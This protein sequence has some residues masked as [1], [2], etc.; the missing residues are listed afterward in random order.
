V[1]WWNENKIRHGRRVAGCGTTAMCVAWQAGSRIS[2]VQVCSGVCDPG[3]Q[4]RSRVW[5]GVRGIQ[6]KVVRQA[7]GVLAGGE[8]VYVCACVVYQG[9]GSRQVKVGGNPNPGMAG[10]HPG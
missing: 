4:V 8:R 10:T 1:G 7:R 9:Q 3:R 2:G 6:P 5:C